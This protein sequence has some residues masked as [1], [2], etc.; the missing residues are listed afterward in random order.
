MDL[1]RRVGSPRLFRDS[2]TITARFILLRTGVVKL[3]T[4]M[5]IRLQLGEGGQA[6]P[7]QVLLSHMGYMGSG[8]ALIQVPQMLEKS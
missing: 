1:G 4:A 3:G 6:R 8:F 7:Q 5:E 2:A